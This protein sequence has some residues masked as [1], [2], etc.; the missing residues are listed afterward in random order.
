MEQ[1]QALKHN[2]KNSVIQL[3]RALAIIAVVL[4][5]DC[6]PEEWQAFC[7]PFIN[8]AV[9]LFLFLSGYLTKDEPRDWKTFF[10]RR[11]TRVLIPYT[12][13]CLLYCCVTVRNLS[14]VPFAFVTSIAYYHLYYILVYMQFVLLT[15]LML[16]LAKSRFRWVGWLVTPLAMMVLVY[17]A[18]FIV[19]DNMLLAYIRL[20]CCLTW[21]VFYYLGL[22][23]GNRFIDIRLSIGK[24]SVLY[25]ISIVLQMVEGYL[26]LR[27]GAAD[28]GN[29]LKLSSI[30]S[31]TIALLIVHEVMREGRVH[32]NNR[33]L[34]LMGD[35]SFGIYLSHPMIKIMLYHLPYYQ[36]IPYPICSV[37]LIVVTTA[38]C[39]Y[40][41]KLAGETVS[42][43]LGLK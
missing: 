17:Y 21:F 33:F 34:L 6:P 2:N 37:I 43:K 4:I 7:R 11:I 24:L 38:F 42:K 8:Y 14:K 35:F 15:P 18:S 19:P 36:D 41:S 27:N 5:H 13:W 16:K 39:Y 1:V 23:L 26:W 25:L 30:I 20:D 9:A 28:I 32:V 12:I 10:T 40:G 22:V 31:S 3:F 29:Q